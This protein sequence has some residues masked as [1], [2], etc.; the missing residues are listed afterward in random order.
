MIFEKLDGQ[1]EKETIHQPLTLPAQETRTNHK[2]MKSKLQSRDREE[3]IKSKE[4]SEKEKKK[5]TSEYSICSAI[6][7]DYKSDCICTQSSEEICFTKS[8]KR[9]SMP[10]IKETNT[11]T[12]DAYIYG[13]Y[14]SH[15]TVKPFKI[16]ESQISV[17][18]G[19]R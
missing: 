3:E 16:D 15:G 4:K 14:I 9:R 8:T 13:H 17:L 6:I 10:L 7:N 18:A 2:G 12:K 11:N 19:I 5:N 1:T